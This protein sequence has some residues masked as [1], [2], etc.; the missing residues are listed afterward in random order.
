MTL[1]HYRGD[2][3]TRHQAEAELLASERAKA[4]AAGA[5]DDLTLK[6]KEVSATDRLMFVRSE[7]RRV[8]K[9]CRL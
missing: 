9:E 7:E 6:L 5:S 3:S 4:A 8:G 2:A 1:G